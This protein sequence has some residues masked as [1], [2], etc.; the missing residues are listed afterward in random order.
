[1][2]IA[3]LP[4]LSYNGIL[5]SCRKNRKK[6]NDGTLGMLTVMKRGKILIHLGQKQCQILKQRVTVMIRGKY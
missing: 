1:M 6:P 3:L 5:I 4:Q 2:N